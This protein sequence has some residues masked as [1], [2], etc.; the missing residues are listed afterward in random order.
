MDYHFNE[1]LVCMKLNFWK[2]FQW[3]SRETESTH[4]VRTA[5]FALRGLFQ[6]RVQTDQ[7]VGSWTSVTQDDLP[8]LLAHLAVILVVCLIAI[9]V[10][11]WG[12]WEVSQSTQ[13]ASMEVLSD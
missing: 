6:L 13:T 4:T 11:F 7:V 8:T 5:P 12:E 1:S 2:Y 3:Y 10:L 9:T